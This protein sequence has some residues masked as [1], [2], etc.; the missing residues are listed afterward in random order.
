MRGSPVGIGVILVLGL[1]AGPLA[2]VAQQPGKVARVGVLSAVQGRS[3]LSYQAFEQGL[4]EFGYVEGQN[5]VLEFRTAEG[6]VE[7]LADLAAELVRLGVD[8]IVAG[9]PEATLQAAWQATRTLPIVMVAVDYDPMARGYI[10]G[11]TRPGGNIT[12]VFL[13][14]I[15]LT[16]KRFQLLLEAVPR[17]SRIAVLWDAFSADQWRAADDG[18]RRLGVHLQSL[19][20][21][22]PP[23][24]DFDSAVGA[25]VREGADALFVLASPAFIHGRDRILTLA[26]QHRLPTMFPARA[27]VEAG[28][29]MAYGANIPDMNQRAAYY[30]DRI[31]KGAKP[32]ELPVE[33]PMK[34]ELI[35]NLKTA[36]GLGITV[37]PSLLLLADKVIQ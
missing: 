10:A 13:R 15:E 23:A 20:L 1:L 5:L 24:Y 19:E 27:W 31:L 26:M 33:Q 11:L 12:G 6:K 32:A 35:I 21:H 9:G 17:A 18:A 37:P 30:V 25:A 29:L 14:Q 34:F 22:H 8:L 28:G 2:A 3:H 16:S 36:K 4:R 7:R